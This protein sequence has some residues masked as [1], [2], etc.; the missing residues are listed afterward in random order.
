VV[1]RSAS[2]P[3]VQWAT[4]R[5]VAAQF[6]IPLREIETDELADPAYRS[7]PTNRCYFCKREL[8]S[9]LRSIANE[10]GG[11][12][13]VDGTNLDDLSDH[14]P[15]RPAGLEVGVRSPLVEL[16]WTKS[17]VRRAAL[18]LGLPIWDAPAGPCLASR[19]QYGLEVTRERL[20]QVESGE[21][22][23]R[24]LGV[25]GDLRVRHHGAR[26]RIEVRPEMFGLV[27][28]AWETINRA[29]RELG[30]EQVT[31][32]PTGYRRGGLLPLAGGLRE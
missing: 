27:D 24:G 1:G 8:W 4:A 17:M 32:D 16:G 22:I 25:V 28:G 26:A 20:A 18:G 23:L 29:F 5:A 6:S 2:Y 10:F 19:I 15:G 31:R 14:R 7:N 3:E 12:V 9:R 13:I 21:R 30:F 11:A